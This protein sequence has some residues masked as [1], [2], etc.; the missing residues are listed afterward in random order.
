MSPDTETTAKIGG[1]YTSPTVARCSAPGGYSRGLLLHY[2]EH[3]PVAGRHGRQ[4]MAGSN[5]IVSEPRPL[6]ASL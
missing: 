4:V 2:P 3:G 5:Q 1:D 6:S